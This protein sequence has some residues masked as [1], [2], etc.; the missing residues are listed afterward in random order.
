MN[1]ENPVIL[2]L[3]NSIEI[4][5]VDVKDYFRIKDIGINFYAIFNNK[6]FQIRNIMST[7]RYYGRYISLANFI[8]GNKEYKVVDHKDRNPLNN[9]PSNLRFANT[10]QNAIN[11]EKMKGTTS[12]YKGVSLYKRTG[13][14][15]VQIVKNKI[16]YF[17]GYFS[18][19]LEAAKAYNDVAQEYQ[20]K[21]AVLNKL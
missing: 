2:S 6:N 4:C 3:T 19:E 10:S 20:G 8:L 18:T 12:K 14:W 17:I 13:R 21:F 7:S 5:L 16:Q 1:E 11:C 9:L 15:K